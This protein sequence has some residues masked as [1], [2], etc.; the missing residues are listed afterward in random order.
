VL[1]VDGTLVF[2]VFGCGEAE[3]RVDLGKHGGR[4]AV[5]GGRSQM[6]CW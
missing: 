1:F 4:L 3:C 5:V 6:E 2:R